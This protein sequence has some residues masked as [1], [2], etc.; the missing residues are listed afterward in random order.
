MSTKDN[1]VAIWNCS[2]SSSSELGVRKLAEALLLLSWGNSIPSRCEL[3]FYWRT[4][5]LSFSRVWPLL[6]QP[7]RILIFLFNDRLDHFTGRQ[8]TWLE[9]LFNES[10]I[11]LFT[12][13]V[14]RENPACRAVNSWETFLT[15]VSKVA[16]ARF[17]S[18]KAI[19]LSGCLDRSPQR[20][21]D[22]H[23]LK[24]SFL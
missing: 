8:W 4:C 19:F 23:W 21:E 13:L 2:S 22:S 9:I 7:K 16:M 6:N 1:F 20:N 5:V 18:W 11:F 17:F 14:T 24:K 12:E 15:Y 10:H 3:G